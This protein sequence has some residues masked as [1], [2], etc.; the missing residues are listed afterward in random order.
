MRLVEQNVDRSR[1][2]SIAL[3]EVLPQI[4]RDYLIE[5]KLLPLVEPDVTPV[6]VEDGSDWEFTVTVAVRPEIKLGEY[7]KVVTT[8]KKTNEFW[9]EVKEDK[10]AD[11][12]AQAAAATKLR[13]DR[14]NAVLTALLNQIK[15]MVPELLLR[16]ETEHQLRQLAQQLEQL[17]IPV[18]KYLEMTKKSMTDLQTETAAR[19]LASLQIEL[20]L[21]AIIA[22]QQISVKPEEVE[23]L[24]AVQHGH[25]A[26]HHHEHSAQEQQYAQSVLLKQKCI[27]FLLSL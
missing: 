2:L 22:D 7:Q 4:Y 27:D 20:L 6:K 21:A 17:R 3:D 1:L 16:R 11:E 18:E 5:H 8:M 25:G 15:V 9:K 10:T 14:L 12:K 23:A 24:L 13:Q 19:A 26:E